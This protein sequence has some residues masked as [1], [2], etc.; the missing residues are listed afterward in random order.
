MKKSGVKLKWM[1]M[2]LSVIPLVLIIGI[3][4]AISVITLDRNLQNSTKDTLF[5]VSNNLARFCKENEIGAMNASN[6]YDYLDSLKDRDIEMAI[7][8]ENVPSTTSIKNENDYRVREVPFDE[9][10]LSGELTLEQGYYE[11][12]VLIDG[13]AY[14]GYYMPIYGD[15]GIRGLAFAG[16]LRNTVRKSIR[17]AMVGYVVTA[18]VMGCL[19]LVTTL[20][21]CRELFSAFQKVED[22]VNVL[23]GGNLRQQAAGKSY[24]HE[25]NILLEETQSLQRNLSHTIGKVKMEAMRLSAEIGEVTIL[26]E[27]NA[28]SA[29]QITS[30]VGDLAGATAGMAQNVQDIQGQMVEIGNCIRDISESVTLLHDSSDHITV[31]NRNARENMQSVLEN[32][33]Q[34]IDAVNDIA[35]QTRNTNASVMEIEKAVEF[36][37]DISRQTK[38]LSLNASIEA[39]RTG[40]VGRGFAVVAE[41]IGNLSEESARGAEMIRNLAGTIIQKSKDSVELADRVQT[42]MG[43]EQE[44]FVKTQTEYE[45]LNEELEQSVAQIRIIADQTQ[46]LTAFKEKVIENV[47]DLSAISEETAAGN[48]E[49]MAHINE[50]MNIIQ[51]V[52]EHCEE[53][54]AM[55]GILEDAVSYFHD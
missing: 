31:T 41:E 20:L 23:A 4:S 25:M 52:N 46:H 22:R 10:I 53:I 51:T 19:F 50:I 42:L 9:N 34:S 18:I 14:C 40:E 47:Q 11:D 1:L 21:F 3:L 38:L 35:A 6:Y 5:I 13:K 45:R 7:I 16:E 37:L 55:A 28:S 43:T 39:A 36:I 24:V 54:R 2:M 49:V 32:N 44:T 17:G 15:T 26:S 30:A 12:N 33:R 8:I 29:T 48:E 27:N